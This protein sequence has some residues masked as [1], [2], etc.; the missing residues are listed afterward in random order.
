MKLSSGFIGK[1]ELLTSPDKY[2]I[3]HLKLLADIF[4]SKK[5]G[6]IFPDVIPTNDL[7]V[8]TVRITNNLKKDGSVSK[9]KLSEVIKIEPV[10][11][12]QD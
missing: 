3:R 8:L 12:R 1:V 6:D 5:I 9:K 4:E 7:V 10:K 2:S 11:N